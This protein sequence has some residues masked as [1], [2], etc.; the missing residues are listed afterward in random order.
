VTNF[1]K[2]FLTTF[3][4]T[5]FS[6]FSSWAMDAKEDNTKIKFYWDNDCLIIHQDDEGQI[7]IDLSSNSIE[8]NFLP[9]DNIKIKNKK[10]N[11]DNQDPLS[12][13]VNF[14]DST[15][16]I[17]LLNGTIRAFGPF[18]IS[19]QTPQLE[20][21]QDYNYLYISTNGFRYEFGPLTIDSNKK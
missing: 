8:N 20:W 13:W 21:S 6:N 5:S 10:N 4:I 7:K 12:N 1:K 16:L 11:N 2:L 14:Q 15:C 9:P 3:L 19:K 17:A 18:S